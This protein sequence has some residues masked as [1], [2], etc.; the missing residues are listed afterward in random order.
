PDARAAHALRL[1]LR[2]LGDRLAL[3]PD[4]DLEA[5]TA[6]GVEERRNVQRLVPPRRLDAP[7]DRKPRPSAS[8]EVELIAVETAALAGADRA[9]VSP[10]SVRVA[11]TLALPSALA[12]VPLPVRI[13]RQVGGVDS[14]WGAETRPP[15]LNH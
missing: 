5:T 3:R 12:D 8:R 4:R 6:Y 11:E 15:R 2:R 10:R 13:R 14:P 7:C 1:R 9:S